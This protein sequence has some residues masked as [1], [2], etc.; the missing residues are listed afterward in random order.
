MNEDHF[1]PD[2]TP[3]DPDLAQVL[4]VHEETSTAR[5]IREALQSF[6]HCQVDSTPNAEYAFERAL[7]RP[8]DLFL[9]SLTMPILHGE[10]LYDLIGKAYKHC[11]DGARSAPG[12]IY[13]GEENHRGRI[14]ELQRDARVKGVLLKPLKIDRVLEKA[15]SVL[16]AKDPI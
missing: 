2:N 12:I 14:D 16:P 13:L 4:L 8:Y 1:L 6:T 15:K 7:Q 10:L 11:H 5:L 9:F 3:V